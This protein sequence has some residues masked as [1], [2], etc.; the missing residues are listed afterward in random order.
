MDS[1]TLQTK[2]IS[3]FLPKIARNLRIARLIDDV[4]PGLTTSQLM[5]LL[6]LQNKEDTP[7]SVGKLAERLSVSFPSASGIID[8]LYKE[9]FVERK[10]SSEDRR[11]VLVELT[12]AG[13]A[14]VAKLIG[15]FEKLLFDVLKNMPETERATI[16]RAAERVSD[17]SKHLS[18]QE[19]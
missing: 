7:L 5:T 14:T 18:L 3:K 11:L 16:V 12:D 2:Q 13:K 19:G 4:K 17:F 10:R 1:L 8:R 6:I 9:K 15:A